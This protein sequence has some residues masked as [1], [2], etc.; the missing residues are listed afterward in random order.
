MGGGG[1]AGRDRQYDKRYGVATL[2]A[3]VSRSA[4]IDIPG[5]RVKVA[6][7]FVPVRSFFHGGGGGGGGRKR[8]PLLYSNDPA[9]KKRGCK[10]T[11]LRFFKN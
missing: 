6:S 7:S 2:P 1:G 5:V 9:H 11:R 4:I 10:K 8:I 3:V